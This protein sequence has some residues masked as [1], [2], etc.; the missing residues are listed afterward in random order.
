MTE[1]ARN[2]LANIAEWM[3]V[4]KLCANPQ[5]TECL[6]IGHPF[7]TR[8]PELLGTLEL[9]GS[10]IK[11]EGKTK[12]LRIIIDRKTWNGMS[13]LSELEAK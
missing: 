6:I 4:N 3:R 1:D 12:Y 9:N 8:K 7:S 11:R 10:E 5:K 13:S 2:E